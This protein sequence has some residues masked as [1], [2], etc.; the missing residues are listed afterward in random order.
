M[1]FMS[2]VKG[3]NLEG[4][5]PAGWDFDKID[6]CCSNA[7]ETICDR[8]D[9]WHKDFKPIPCKNV[10]E[11]DMMMGHEIANQIKMARE[12]GLK[13]IMILNTIALL[14]LQ[15]SAVPIRFLSI[16]P[17]VKSAV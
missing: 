16:L 13:L 3:S 12:E 7:P 2:T 4:F 8:Q 14:L 6:A 17:N 15:C 10:S 1:N 5:Y 11:F 9:F